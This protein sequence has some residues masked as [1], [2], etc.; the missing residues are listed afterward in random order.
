[1]FCAE[2][3][4]KKLKWSDCSGIRKLTSI[5][6]Y[7]YMARKKKRTWKSQP[8]N[9][10]HA[11]CQ[12]WLSAIRT[13]ISRAIEVHLIQTQFCWIPNSKTYQPTKVQY[14][15]SSYKRD[16][17]F[18]RWHMNSANKQVLWRNKSKLHLK[19]SK[20][21]SKSLFWQLG[22]SKSKVKVWRF[23]ARLFLLF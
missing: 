15:M 2:L 7:T 5:P 4:L 6:F 19:A 13:W 20:P 16:M 3:E 22:S 21:T 17:I 9:S 10:N 18:L 11:F 23:Y 8:S 14:K 12:C 1:M